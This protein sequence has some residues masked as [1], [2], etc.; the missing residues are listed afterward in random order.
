KK[1]INFDSAVV[2]SLHFT[3]DNYLDIEEPFD[4]IEGECVEFV[5]GYVAN[6]FSNKYPDL[7]DLVAGEKKCWTNHI[8]RGQLKIPSDNL[9]RQ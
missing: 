3:N 9:L 5:A 1:P 2:C 8:S 6:R 7:I 4:Q